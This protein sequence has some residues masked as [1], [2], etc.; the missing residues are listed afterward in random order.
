MIPLFRSGRGAP[1]AD[2]LRF[3]WPTWEAPPY[4]LRLK[5]LYFALRAAW[6]GGPAPEPR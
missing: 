5:P 3:T 2:L 4:A 1:W 6:K